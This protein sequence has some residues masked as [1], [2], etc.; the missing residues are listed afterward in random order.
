MQRRQFSGALGGL[1]LA[2]ALTGYTQ[3]SLGASNA[4]ANAGVLP[5][6]PGAWPPLSV[7]AA[8]GW[9]SPSSTRAA[10]PPTAT[11]RGALPHVQHLQAAGGRPRAASRRHRPGAAR[12]KGPH[13]GRR[14]PA[15]LAHDA[16]AHRPARPA[17]GGAVRGNHHPQRQRG[18]QPDAGQLRRPRRTHGLPAQPGR[19][20][21]TTGPQRT[22]TQRSHTRRPKRDTTTPEA[23]LAT[24][25]KI[26]LG[27]AL[28]DASRKQIVQW[29]QGN[30]TGDQRLRAL[31]PAG[32][33]VGDKTGSGARGSTNDVGLLWP[34]GGRAPLLVAAY[35]TE[36]KQAA[37]QRDATLAKVGQLAHRWYRCEFLTDAKKPPEGGQ[38]KLKIRRGAA[39]R[40]VVN[41]C[42]GRAAQQTEKCTEITARHKATK[43]RGADKNLRQIAHQITVPTGIGL[44]DPR[45]PPETRE[46]GN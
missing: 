44:H 26:T 34:P 15:P 9:A 29:L 42:P 40:L 16:A 12:T 13:R 28:S 4:P 27:T 39:P 21:D 5:P 11:A 14:H 45:A 24:M 3:K 22:R 36:T 43:S 35:L 20:G 31:L 37:A 32:W 2:T 38:E 33:R 10:A 6:S 17:H 23:M 46:P 8:A 18:R 19:Q 1:A 41:P 7:P 30:K 25:Q